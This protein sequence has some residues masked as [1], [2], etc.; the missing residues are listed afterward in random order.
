M[1]E[2]DQKLKDR[3]E[4]AY[5]IIAGLGGSTELIIQV[6]REIKEEE[7][8]VYKATNKNDFGAIGSLEEEKAKEIA[9]KKEKEE[10]EAW[11]KLD[12]GLPVTPEKPV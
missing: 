10:N 4:R 7:D 3:Y 12:L 11:G 5:A 1:N 8:K 6:A 2:I 9:L